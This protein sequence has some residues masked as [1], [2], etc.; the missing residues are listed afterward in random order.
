MTLVSSWV[1]QVKMNSSITSIVLTPESNLQ[2]RIPNQMG[3]FHFLTLWLCHK[4]P[5]GSIKTT[6][7]R[8]PTHTDMYL[9][10]DSYH[11]LSAK[12]SVINTLRHREKTVCSTKQLLTEEE[13]HLYNVLR[14][15]KYPL[16]A[17]NRT[18]IKKRKKNNNQGNKNIKKSY[19]VLSYMKGLGE[20]C[21]NICRRY[22]VEVYFRGGSTIRDLLVH[23]KD[24]DTILKKSGVIYRCRCG[25][26]DCEEEYIGESGRTFGERYR[27]HMRAPSPIMDHQNTT[28]H[29]V[30]L[31]NFSIVGR[32]DNS[33]ARNIK[34]AIFIRVNGPSLNR[35]IGKFQLP[36]IWDE[37]LARSP[38]LHLK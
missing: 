18:N 14:R 12:Y 19:I 35:N 20:I 29:E 17:W 22:G 6:V 16:W 24:R 5:D 28:G 37:V 26:V 11:H 13:D 8:K 1:L 10:W 25:R 30:S 9:H 33:I 38:E 23:P 27:E 34:E 3:Q 21:K 31:D 4:Q 2:V 36:H 7:F 15:C 32:E